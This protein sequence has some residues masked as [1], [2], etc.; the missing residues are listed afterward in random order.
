VE[1]SAAVPPRR[2]WADHFLLPADAAI[3]Q[4]VMAIEEKIAE[5]QAEQ[6]RLRQQLVSGNHRKALFVGTGDGFAAAAREAFADLG[7]KVERAGNGETSFVLTHAAQPDRHAVAYCAGTAG[8]LG[9]REVIARLLHL[10]ASYFATHGEL[11]KILAVLNPNASQPLDQRDE[12][13]FD[14]ALV[15]LAGQRGWCVVSGLQLMGMTLDG[16]ESPEKRENLASQLH[17]ATGTLD[18]YADWQD[19]LVKT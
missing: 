13:P 18:S 4:Q 12:A 8:A 9:G 11:P 3:A 2:E 19:F 1:R 10:E 5:L 15:K 7:Y 6:K 16:E 17:D 14:G